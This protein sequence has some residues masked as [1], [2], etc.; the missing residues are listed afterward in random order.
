MTRKRKTYWLRMLNK[1]VATALLTAMA[2]AGVKVG[3]DPFMGFVA[4]PL[5]MLAVLLGAVA[6]D[7]RVRAEK[8]LAMVFEFPCAQRRHHSQ[9]P[10]HKLAA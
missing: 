2:V 5:A 7:R 1:T 4:Q 9:G 3:M 8:P 6:V 10:D